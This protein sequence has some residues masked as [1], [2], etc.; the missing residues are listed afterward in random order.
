MTSWWN[1]DITM[2]SCPDWAAVMC[3]TVTVLLLCCLI[4]ECLPNLFKVWVWVWRPLLDWLYLLR[5]QEGLRSVTPG[6]TV[7]ITQL[8]SCCRLS[9]AIVASVWQII[10]SPHVFYFRISK[11]IL[12]NVTLDFFSSVFPPPSVFLFSCKLSFCLLC[13]SSSFFPYCLCASFVT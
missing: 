2:T 1:H 9:V 6:V 4:N 10:T 12:F 7:I 11:K 8:L 13:F 5:V 3:C